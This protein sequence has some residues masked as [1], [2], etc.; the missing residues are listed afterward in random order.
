MTT[1]AADLKKI[2]DA[3]DYVRDTEN[4]TQ[5]W[6][7]ISVTSDF[8]LKLARKGKEY[9]ELMQYLLDADMSFA[10]VKI[11]MGDEVSRREKFVL[12]SWVGSQVSSVKRGRMMVPRNE[13][14]TIFDQR[15]KVIEPSDV[16]DLDI[17]KVKEVLVKAGGADY[18]ASTS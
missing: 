15:A 17:A 2:T 11:I 13:I 8:K 18:G 10:Y 1:Q 7:L 14:D 3:R 16:S 5:V 12:I 4:E 6:A 9:S